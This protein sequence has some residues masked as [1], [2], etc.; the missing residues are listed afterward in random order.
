MSVA[1][2]VLAGEVWGVGG[3]AASRHPGSWHAA[4]ALGRHAAPK[5]EGVHGTKG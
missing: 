2:R 1:V 4:G 3:E 5:D